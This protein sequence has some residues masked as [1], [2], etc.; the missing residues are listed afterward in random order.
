MKVI[1]LAIGLATVLAT[2]TTMTMT[3]Q[4]AFA[5]INCTTE[6]DVTTCSG[7]TGEHPQPGIDGGSGSHVVCSGVDTPEPDCS[8]SGGGGGG[9]TGG[10]P[11]FHPDAPGGGG[12]GIHSSCIFDIDCPVRGG[13]GGGGR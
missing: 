3:T 10:N 7:G 4:I 8:V 12:A 9:G 2:V 6:N 1:A 13:G 5:A 11:T